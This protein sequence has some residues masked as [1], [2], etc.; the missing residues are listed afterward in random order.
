M[1]TLFIRVAEVSVCNFT[2]KKRTKKESALLFFDCKIISRI[3][4]ILGKKRSF[5][6]YI[7]RRKSKVRQ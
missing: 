6:L 7:E 5:P 4:F 3:I 2:G 1:P